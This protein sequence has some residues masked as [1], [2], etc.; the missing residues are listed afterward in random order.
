MGQYAASGPF[1][2]CRR[3]ASVRK[4]LAAGCGLD[5]G[6]VDQNLRRGKTVAGALA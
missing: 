5:R 4:T 6:F 1:V 2:D 3:V